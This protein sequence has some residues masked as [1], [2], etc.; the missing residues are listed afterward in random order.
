MVAMIHPRPRILPVIIRAMSIAH[1]AGAKNNV[2]LEKSSV[3][4]VSQP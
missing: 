1:V 3:A 2:G 4:V